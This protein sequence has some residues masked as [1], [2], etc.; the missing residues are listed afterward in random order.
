[1]EPKYKLIVLERINRVMAS[2]QARSTQHHFRC[3]HRCTC[4]MDQ[5]EEM[6]VVQPQ[7]QEDDLTLN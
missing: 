6:E 7:Q 4:S 1:M 3:D 5:L 2:V